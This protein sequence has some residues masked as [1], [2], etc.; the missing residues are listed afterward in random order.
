MNY[1]DRL[2]EIEQDHLEEQ[3][4]R[5]IRAA[6]E[7]FVA[8]HSGILHVP[9]TIVAN[10][11]R[12]HTDHVEDLATSDDLYFNYKAAERYV[13]ARSL[14]NCVEDTWNPQYTPGDGDE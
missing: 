11:L 6:E 9:A 4:I 2:L 13:I 7:S 5:Q 1:H 12:I 3:H 10:D 8:D 14:A